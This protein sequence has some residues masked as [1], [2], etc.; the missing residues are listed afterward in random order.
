MNKKGPVDEGSIL[1]INE[2]GR[3]IVFGG[4]HPAERKN[5]DFAALRRL[6]PDGEELDGGGAHVRELHPQVQSMS[7]SLVC[8]QPLLVPPTNWPPMMW[9][10]SD[11]HV[12]PLVHTR[13]TPYS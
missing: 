4:C 1:E 10:G 7:P 2:V 3:Q 8:V 11:A 5:G 6:S 12:P 9:K 13:L